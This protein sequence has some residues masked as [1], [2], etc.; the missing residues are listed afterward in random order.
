M[1]HIKLSSP[2]VDGCTGFLVS[3]G[4]WWQLVVKRGSNTAVCIASRIVYVSATGYA[5]LLANYKRR[6]YSPWHLII[7][8]RYWH[9]PRDLIEAVHY[10]RTTVDRD[11]RKFL[12]ECRI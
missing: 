8:Q 7:D 5:E 9:M 12:R 11:S 2:P 6:L 3:N 1:K 10:V 4:L